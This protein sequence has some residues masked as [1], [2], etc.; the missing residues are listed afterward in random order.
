MG[1]HG[2]AIRALLAARDVA[3][4]HIREPPN[5]KRVLT[6]LVGAGAAG[7]VEFAKWAR[8]PEVEAWSAVPVF[9][10]GTGRQDLLAIR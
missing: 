4:E 3:P 2:Y 7:A 5:V 6:V 8:A 10:A 9:R 1:Q